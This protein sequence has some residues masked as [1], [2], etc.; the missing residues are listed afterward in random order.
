MD[1]IS[2]RVCRLAGIPGSVVLLLLLWPGPV[3][4]DPPEAAVPSTE[5][6]VRVARLIKDLGA[7]DFSTRRSAHQQLSKLGAES[8]RQLEKA[9]EDPDP[10]IQLRARQLLE[11]WKL[12]ELWAPSRVNLR[13]SGEKASKILLELAEQSGNHIHVGDPYG[14]FAEQKIDA[15]YSDVCYWEAE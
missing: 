8:H 7:R 3:A 1:W 12:D 15:D 4:A 14:T 11:R 10:E 2:P 6:E 5:P 9:L 13:I